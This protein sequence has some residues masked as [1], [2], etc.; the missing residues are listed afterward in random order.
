MRGL[1]GNLAWMTVDKS[2]LRDQE[3]KMNQIHPGYDHPGKSYSPRCEAQFTSRLLFQ[4]SESLDFPITINWL[5]QCEP[6]SVG[7]LKN[8]KLSW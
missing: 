7:S 6:D 1:G 2:L 4:L 3:L 8:Q 5:Q